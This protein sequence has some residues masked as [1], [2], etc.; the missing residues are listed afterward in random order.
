MFFL[1]FSWEKNVGGL[2]FGVCVWWQFL[3]G[4]IHLL[5]R[6][7]R[8]REI[9]SYRLSCITRFSFFFPS[10]CIYILKSERE[11]FDVLFF[12][13]KKMSSFSSHA[14]PVHEKLNT[15]VSVYF[16]IF[17]TFLPFFFF[18]F[19]LCVHHQKSSRHSR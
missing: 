15:L 2:V 17:F 11:T 3:L 8:I 6:Q 13:F 5:V 19:L 18:S 7:D 16:F 14:S 1:L 4:Y 10:R 12:Y 9:L